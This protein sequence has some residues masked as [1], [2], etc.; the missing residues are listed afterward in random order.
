MAHHEIQTLADFATAAVPLQD[1]L[2]LSRKSSESVP[3]PWGLPISR[4]RNPK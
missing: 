4:H 1:A 2:G 3:W